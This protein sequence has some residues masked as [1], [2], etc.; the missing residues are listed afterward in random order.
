MESWRHMQKKNKTKR[1]HEASQF[2]G[3][4]KFRY[5]VKKPEEEWNAHYMLMRSHK[6][7]A[8]HAIPM[9]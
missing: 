2:A 7:A 8:F 6:E 3:G 4:K 5:T 9:H 1:L